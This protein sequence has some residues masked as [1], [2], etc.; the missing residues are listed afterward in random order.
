MAKSVKPRTQKKAVSRK[1]ADGWHLSLAYSL[2]KTVKKVSNKIDKTQKSAG[3]RA[4]GK[5]S[6]KKS[7]ELAP[8]ELFRVDPGEPLTPVLKELKA[9]ADVS[10]LTAAIQEMH[11]ISLKHSTHPV[12]LRLV[13]KVQ[14][15]PAAEQERLSR[16][17][18][19]RI[20]ER[21]ESY[22]AFYA[23]PPKAKMTEEDCQKVS[24]TF[25]ECL[26]LTLE[27]AGMTVQEK[28]FLQKFS[29]EVT[30]PLN[31]LVLFYLH[32][33]T[34]GQKVKRLWRMQRIIVKM[35][36]LVN[37]SNALAKRQA[38]ASE[39]AFAAGPVGP[40]NYWANEDTKPFVIKE[41][42]LIVK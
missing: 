18:V 5:G 4:V 26:T 29:D 15:L 9:M 33:K 22:S 35:I 30:R 3:K 27:D 16:N 20:R 17:F 25:I 1:K 37:L 40:A 34:F 38:E 21:M 42:D 36:K 19:E 32:P 11:A 41:S 7:S 12:V 23:F 10:G 8:V 6:R 13:E 31:E 39:K 14:Q 28:E 2:G 24:N